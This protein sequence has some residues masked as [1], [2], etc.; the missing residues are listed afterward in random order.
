MNRSRQLSAIM[1]TD[2]AGYTALMGNDEQEAFAL[3][4]KNREVQQPVIERFGGKWIKEIGDGV[5]ASFSTVTDAVLCAIE[6][7]ETCGCIP[8]LKLRIGIHLGE[9]VFENNDVFGDGVNIASRLQ[10]LAP[11]GG[12]WVSDSVHKNVSNKKE[13]KTKFVRAAMLKNVKEEVHI[14][15]IMMTQNTIVTTEGQLKNTHLNSIAVLPFTNMSSDP[16]QEFFSDGISEEIINMLVQVPNLKVTGRTSSFSFKRKNEDL[17]SVGEKLNVRTILEGSVRSFG[18]RIRIT[19]QLVDVQSGFHLWSEKYD[20]ILNDIFEV[21][22]EIARAIADKLQ[23]SLPGKSVEPKSR[24]QTQNV[25]AYQCYLKGRALLYRRG[26][27][28]FEAITL[29][30]KALIIDPAYALAHS[31]LADTYTVLCLY[32]FTEPKLAWPKAIDSAKLA[33]KYGPNLTESQNCSAVIALFYE[34]EV[35]K[36]AS[37]FLK[38]IDL[39]P[40]FEQPRAW[41]GC[42]VLN[43]AY[44]KHEEAVNLTRLTL[45]TNPLSAYSNTVAGITLGISG[46]YE[47]SIEKGELGAEIDPNSFFSQFYLAS[48]YHWSGDY[49]VSCEKFEAMLKVTNRHPWP[50]C[51]LTVAYADWGKKDKANELYKE[52]LALSEK[53]YLQPGILALTAA[54]LG[55]EVEALKFA[56][57]A[58]DE[59]DPILNLFGKCWPSARALLSIPGYSEILKTLYNDD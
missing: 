38:S 51:I 1:F 6:I 52:L 50:M 34:R 31:G 9:V 35:D 54:A 24:E 39:N 4:K 12:I 8:E 17:R 40:G 53:K 19:V 55:N 11:V 23:S 2:I 20:R 30:E 18:N 37:L 41:Y 32:G 27:Y 59:R 3:L 28:L 10:A 44:L 33:M 58:C 45:N 15:E 29:F 57:L 46:K 56:Q 14:Y 5:L 26:K 43:L 22:D 21:Q 25:E 42:F 16:E 49:H 36:A 47:E 7:Q 13:I 48:M